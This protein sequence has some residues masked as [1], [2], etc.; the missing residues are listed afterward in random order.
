ML[1][2]SMGAPQKPNPV[3]PAERLRAALAAIPLFAALEPGDLR[4][5][6]GC[7]RTERVQAADIVIERGAPA[8]ALYAVAAGKLKVVAPRHAGRDATLHILGP[9]DVFGEVALFDTEG[10]TARVT[11]IEESVLL[12]IDRREFVDLLSRSPELSRRLLS[13]MANRIKNTIAHFDA[14]TS[15]DVPQRLARKLLFLAEHYGVREGTGV[16]ITLKLSQSELGDLVDST[17]QSV[18]RELRRWNEAGILA[19]DDGRIVVVDA[20]ALRGIADPG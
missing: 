2:V 1:Q 16:A 17:R 6:S 13:L 7:A 12:V 15:L 10:R 20:A 14:T 4:R 19:M 9:G 5:I 8:D 11:A 3:A 18:N